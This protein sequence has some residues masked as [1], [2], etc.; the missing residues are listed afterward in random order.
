[1][2]NE[3]KKVQESHLRK[4]REIFNLA[5]DVNL[6]TKHHAF[7]ALSPHVQCVRVDIHENGWES[8]KEKYVA[9]SAYYNDMESTNSKPDLQFGEYSLQAIINVLRAAL[10]GTLDFDKYQ[11]DWRW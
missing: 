5:L 11:D 1:M 10:D 2:D 9:M 8:N 6:K 3:E 7:F 4:V